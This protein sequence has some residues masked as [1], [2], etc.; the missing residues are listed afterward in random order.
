MKQQEVKLRFEAH[1]GSPSFEMVPC[2]EVAKNRYR[3][4]GS[5]GF[6]PGVAMGDEIELLDAGDLGYR[7]VERSGNV[8]IRL[9][10]NRCSDRDRTQMAAMAERLD[11]MV[12]GGL[13]TDSSHLLIL[14]MHLSSGFDAIEQLMEQITRQFDVDSWMYGNV[15][16]PRDGV[17]PLNW[18]E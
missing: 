9:F 17:T 7:V 5:P 16:D 6:A 4:E 11:G 12:D 18:W 8:C 3:L 1:E 2:T 15:Y 13:D 10:L 14:T